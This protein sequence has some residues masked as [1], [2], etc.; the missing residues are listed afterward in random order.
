MRRGTD[1]VARVGAEEFALMLPETNEAAA[2]IVA[3]RL[4]SLIESHSKI[5]PGKNTQISVSIGVVSATPD[6]PTFEVMLKRADEALYEAKRCGR[7]Q[8]V[9]AP[10]QLSGDSRSGLNWRQA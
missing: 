2:A 10:R 6:M 5:F 3:E 7:N 8:V 4:R 9:T 1:I